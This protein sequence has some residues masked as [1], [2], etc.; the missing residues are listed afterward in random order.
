MEER[1][2][3]IR[4]QLRQIAVLEMEKGKD[5]DKMLDWN[6]KTIEIANVN[7][8]VNEKQNLQM[9]YDLLM[10]KQAELNKQEEDLNKE[11]NKK[12]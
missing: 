11:K 4:K 10:S 12:E 1:E 7:D 6:L 3:R 8:L 2:G 5:E 9:A